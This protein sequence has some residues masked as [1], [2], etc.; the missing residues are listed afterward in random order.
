MFVTT[1]NGILA[2]IQTWNTKPL[3]KVKPIN[4]SEVRLEIMKHFLVY[5]HHATPSDII[6][7]IEKFYEAI[8]RLE[9]VINFIH[10]RHLYEMYRNC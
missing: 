4:P 7:L 8:P 2:T 3:H 5:P 6:L 9:Y 1:F 10:L